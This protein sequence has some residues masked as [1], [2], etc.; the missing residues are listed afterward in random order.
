MDENMINKCDK[1]GKNFSDKRSLIRHK[2]R[3]NPCVIQ[4]ADP[5]E[6]KN[7]NRCIHCNKILSKKEHL[8]RHIKTC[9]IKNRGIVEIPD[10]NAQL[11]EQVRILAEEQKKRDDYLKKEL[12]IQKQETA[13]LKQMLANA[14]K[15]LADK[16]GTSIVGDNNIVV[17]VTVNKFTRPNI[18]FYHDNQNHPENHSV[19]ADCNGTC[20]VMGDFGWEVVTL[21]SAAEEVRKTAIEKLLSKNCY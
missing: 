15:A 4:L 1:C 3:K 11:A 5:I 13:E 7:S 16:S 14:L 19:I 17:N 6:A 12:D 10:P 8:I 18:Q 21:D 20:K 2:N 9:K